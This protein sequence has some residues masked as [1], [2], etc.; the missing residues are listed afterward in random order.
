[1]NDVTAS[2]VSSQYTTDPFFD[3]LVETF[4]TN[5]VRPFSAND[6]AR[7]SSESEPTSAGQEQSPEIPGCAVMVLAP[8]KQPLQVKSLEA[9]S[10]TSAFVYSSKNMIHAITGLCAALGVKGNNFELL[11]HLYGC[12]NDLMNIKVGHSTLAEKFYKKK[13]REKRLNLSDEK[14]RESLVKNIGMVINRAL[15]WFDKSG[16]FYLYRYEQSHE[17]GIGSLHKVV[18]FKLAWCI[19]RKAYRIHDAKPGK[20]NMRGLNKTIDT[21]VDEAARKLKKVRPGLDR[22]KKEKSMSEQVMEA[23][24]RT[25]AFV[26]KCLMQGDLESLRSYRDRHLWALNAINFELGEVFA[27]NKVVESTELHGARRRAYTINRTSMFTSPSKVVATQQ[28]VESQDGQHTEDKEDTDF[29]TM[30]VRVSEARRTLDIFRQTHCR[31]VGVHHINDSE[32]NQDKKNTNGIEKY[33]IEELAR[34]ISVELCEVDS[35]QFSYVIRPY[36]KD[37]ACYYVHIDDITAEQVEELKDFAFFVIKTSDERFKLKCY[38]AWLCVAGADKDYATR[39]RGK[40]DSDTGASGAVRLP[41][42]FNYKPEYGP[43]FPLVKIIYATPRRVIQKSEVEA[44]GLILPAPPVESRPKVHPAEPARNYTTQRRNGKGGL[45]DYSTSLEQFGHD[46]S[47]ADWNWT[48]AAACNGWTNAEELAE[49]LRK[50][51][52]RAKT[53]KLEKVVKE[54]EKAIKAALKRLHQ[55]S[56][57]VR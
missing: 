21:L 40:F 8:S 29:A 28:F 43:N 39:I 2:D 24:G 27:E 56:N 42:S 13:I 30:Q 10:L 34:F 3:D 48:F 52:E 45:L 22:G 44:A 14:D 31:I 12:G 6:L 36:V 16:Y 32:L 41:G 57:V 54:C 19:V 18:L 46:R 17:L 49:E 33:N 7:E 1:M 20:S 26:K 53:M 51:S 5:L 15:D 55:E 47:R 4:S 25:L 38:Q 11:F 37:D 50:V 9:G 23:N 35:K